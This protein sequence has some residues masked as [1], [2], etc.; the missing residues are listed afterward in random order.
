V[1]HSRACSGIAGEN[2][3]VV[4][5]GEHNEVVDE[6]AKDV[7]DAMSMSGGIKLKI[8]DSTICATSWQFKKP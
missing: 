7:E 6:G 1:S 4:V 2:N 3:E 5:A 8:S